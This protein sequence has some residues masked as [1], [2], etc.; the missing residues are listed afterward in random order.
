MDNQAFNPAANAAPNVAPGAAP[1]PHLQPA[2]AANQSQASPNFKTPVQKAK[3]QRLALIIALI[4]ISLLAAVFIGLFVWMYV[5]WDDVSTDVNGRIDQAVAIAV[6]EK[7][8]ELEAAF[9]EREKHPYRTFLGPADYGSLT[10]DFPK[11][12]SVYIPDDANY[13]GDYNAYLN[14]DKV[15]IVAKDTINALRVSIVNKS[16]DEIIASYKRAVEKGELTTSTYN[17]NGVNATIYAG[18]L[19][20]KLKG[21]IAVFKLRDKTVIMQTDAEIFKDDFFKILDTVRFNA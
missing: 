10:F 11:T 5:L 17:V 13:G 15:S 8:T 16:T 6:N 21:Y 7:Q 2:P 1:N 9:E 19:P 4:A 18:T 14:P 20:S 12:W 3:S